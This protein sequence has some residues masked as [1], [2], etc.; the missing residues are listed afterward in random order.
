MKNGEKG[1]FAPPYYSRFK[2]K[3]DRCRHSCCIDWEIIVDAETLQKYRKN[4]KIME[5]VDESGDDACFRLREDGKCPHLNSSGLCELIISHGEEYLSEICRNH[6]RFFNAVGGRT[7]AGLGIVCEEACR[8]VLEYDGPFV[9]HKIGECEDSVESDFDATHERERIM[10][11]IDSESTFEE[12]LA[13]LRADYGIRE[14]KSISEWAE[15]YLTLETLDPEWT[16]YLEKL[17]DYGDSSQNGPRGEYGKLYSGL[18]GYF[19][20]RHVSVAESREDLC[21]RLAFAVLSTEMIR[22]LFENGTEHSTE[23]LG[24]IARRY[25]AEVE[26]SREN[27]EEVLLEIELG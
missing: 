2:C 19:V 14:T 9:L 12:K 26:Y 18:M 20:Y 17:R 7:E 6:P 13:R 21:T 23:A 5:T 10:E 22:R 15:F 25:S 3:A 11:I 8:L 1:L 27:T 16:E 4:S 24:D